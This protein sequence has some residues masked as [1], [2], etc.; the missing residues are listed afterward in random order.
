MSE[1]KLKII[2]GKKPKADLFIESHE[3]SLLSLL[4]RKHPE[5]AK[6]FLSRLAD[7][8]REPKAA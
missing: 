7:A 4:I 6:E 5:R 1:S 8:M 3:L 2:K